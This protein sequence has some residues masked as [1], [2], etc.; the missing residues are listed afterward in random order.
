MAVDDEKILSELLKDILETLGCE[1]VS[2]NN[3]LEAADYYAGHPDFD[4]VMLDVLMPHLSGV[5]LYYRLQKS[6]PGLK[7][8]FMSGYSKDTEVE[9]IVAGNSRTAFIKKPYN[10]AELGEKLRGLL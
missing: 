1:V 9:K 3:P 2:F 4:V 8:I 10:V 6:N 5:E 7:V